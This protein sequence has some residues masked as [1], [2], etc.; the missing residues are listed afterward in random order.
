MDSH[1]HGFESPKPR[2]LVECIRSDEVG[3]RFE[4]FFRKLP[5]FNENPK[6]S[7]TNK[8][9]NNVSMTVNVNVQLSTVELSASFLVYVCMYVC[10]YVGR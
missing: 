2:M 3:F 9:R 6:K 4:C 10:M 1:P 5:N 7:S 8:S